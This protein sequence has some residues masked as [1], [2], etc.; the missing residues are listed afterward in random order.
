MGRTPWSARDA[1]SRF[2]GGERRGQGV[3]PTTDERSA[4]ED[5]AEAVIGGNNWISSAREAACRIVE[6]AEI[7]RLSV[8]DQR[9]I[10]DAILN[11]PKP[12]LAL[13]RDFN[14]CA[15]A[16]QGSRSL[17]KIAEVPKID[18]VRYSD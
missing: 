9:R 4:R 1:P 11:P 15:E 8:E 5:R 18:K 3:R 17:P 6:R 7:L 14:A 16:S 2:F 13:R 10:A 12:T